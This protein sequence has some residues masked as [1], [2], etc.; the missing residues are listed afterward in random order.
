[1]AV[2]WRDGLALLSSL[3]ASTCVRI[4]SSGTS[5]CISDSRG[6][7]AVIT[8]LVSSVCGDQFI[9]AKGGTACSLVKS[10]GFLRQQESSF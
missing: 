3:V 7:P 2:D 9:L 4:Y 8:G 5:G 6:C 1:M 10:N